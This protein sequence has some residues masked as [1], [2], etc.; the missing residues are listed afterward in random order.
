MNTTDEETGKW[1]IVHYFPHEPV[2]IYGLFDSD[3]EA[4]AYAERQMPGWGDGQGAYTVQMV[5]N[6]HLEVRREPWE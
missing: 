2:Q 4:I 1:V 5:L 3:T 6:A